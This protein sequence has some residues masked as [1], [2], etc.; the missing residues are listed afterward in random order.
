MPPPADD[1]PGRGNA[2]PIRMAPTMR[3]A[4]RQPV[5]PWYAATRVL[6]LLLALNVLPYFNRGAITGDVQLYHHWLT[7][8]FDHGRYPLDDQKW[9]Y[10]P[11]AAAPLLLP[12]W[13]PGS[14]YVLF[15]LLCLAADV[16][17]GDPVVLHVPDQDG[18]T[19]KCRRGARRPKPGTK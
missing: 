15:F 10:P 6:L 1:A 8:S 17:K 7:Q 11:G 18:H 4:R 16:A 12:H 19:T 9:Q 2:S 5:V 13:L 3:I 14:Y